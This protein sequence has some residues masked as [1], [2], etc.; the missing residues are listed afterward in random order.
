MG[1]GVSFEAIVNKSGINMGRLTDSLTQR[2]A[3]GQH[4]VQMLEQNG[5]TVQIFERNPLLEQILTEQK[6]TNQLLEWI[7]QR[8]A[9]PAS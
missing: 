3:Q 9:P 5:N 7:G 2:K 1:N 6:R 8:L 4:L